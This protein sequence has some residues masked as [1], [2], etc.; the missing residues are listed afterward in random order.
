[1]AERD[2]DVMSVSDA[3]VQDAQEAI[4]CL[5][6][7]GHDDRGS[8]AAGAAPAGAADAAAPAGE[9]AR[10]HRATVDLATRGV[11]EAGEEVGSASIYR[12]YDGDA[13][14]PISDAHH[15]AH[16]D[17]RLAEFTPTEFKRAFRVRKATTKGDK[18]WLRRGPAALQGLG[19]SGGAISA[20]GRALAV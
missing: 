5:L 1:M 15:Y 11:A 19:R 14:R 8:C 3:S 13:G 16:R 9:T 12:R 7:D 10:R 17:V 20:L 18:E 2:A 6:E 4:A